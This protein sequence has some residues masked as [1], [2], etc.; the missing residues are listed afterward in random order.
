MGNTYTQMP[1]HA[2]FAVQGRC[3]FLDDHFR[4]DLFRYM[5]VILKNDDAFPL[6]VNGWRDHVH[7]LFELKPTQRVADIMRELKSISTKWINE[8]GFLRQKFQWQQGYGAFACSRSHRDRAIKYI[9]NQ[10]I[11]HSTR[12]FREEY[13]EFLKIAEIVYD[14]RYLFTFYD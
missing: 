3:N 8:Q 7:V 2:V 4:E 6:A 5:S 14:E 10:E 13:I 11:H 1:I 9:M 12:S